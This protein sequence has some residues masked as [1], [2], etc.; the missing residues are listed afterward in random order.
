L[1]VPVE[2]SNICEFISDPQRPVC[3]K[4]ARINLPSYHSGPSQQ[5]IREQGGGGMGAN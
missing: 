4:P 5:P 2:L 3:R 1:S